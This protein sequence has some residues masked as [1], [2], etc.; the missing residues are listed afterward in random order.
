MGGEVGGKWPHTVGKRGGVTDLRSKR[1]I[2]VI[3]SVQ[4]LV[5]HKDEA[6]FRSFVCLL[7]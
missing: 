3:F 4:T 1:L 5:C 6:V 2:R 7:Y